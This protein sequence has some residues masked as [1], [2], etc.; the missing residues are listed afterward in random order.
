MAFLEWVVNFFLGIFAKEAFYRLTNELP[1]LQGCLYLQ[2][3][4]V[5]VNT[6]AAA[7]LAVL[8]EGGL[9]FPYDII[10]ISSALIRPGR[11]KPS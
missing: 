11:K 7:R 10:S 2:H 3:Q 8:F 6:P 5:C 1:L 9:F 4:G